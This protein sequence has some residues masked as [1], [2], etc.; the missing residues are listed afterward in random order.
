MSETCQDC[1]SPYE[2][3]YRVPDEVWRQISPKAS[4]GDG[5]GGL[6]CLHCAEVRAWQKGIT[7][8]W[9]AAIGNFPSIVAVED[10]IRLMLSG[11]R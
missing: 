10:Y 3:V 4:E 8:Y 2:E 1:G 11:R 6:L 9:E 7:L 5:L